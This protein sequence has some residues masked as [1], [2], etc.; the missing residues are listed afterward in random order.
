MPQH[1]VSFVAHIISHTSA[2]THF[3][4]IPLLYCLVF[5]DKRWQRPDYKAGRKNSAD[6]ISIDKM[7]PIYLLQ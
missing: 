6:A 2:K 1:Q 7:W 5:P 4:L 3:W